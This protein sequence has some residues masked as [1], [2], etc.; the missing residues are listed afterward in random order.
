MGMGMG[1]SCSMMERSATMDGMRMGG[2]KGSDSTGMMGG[3]RMGMMGGGHM[4]MMP[5]SRMMMAG[6]R[7]MPDRVLGLAD[8]LGLTEQQVAQI[9]EIKDS[10]DPQ[11]GHE[12]MDQ[13]FEA[14]EQAF[15]AE[16]PNPEA[17]QATAEAALTM[18]AQMQ[19]R[20]LATATAVRAVL[21]GEQRDRLEASGGCSMSG[22]QRSGM[23]DRDTEGQRKQL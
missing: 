22:S 10:M 3:G 11:Q 23:H 19:A 2:M 17:V 21:S 16:E 12:S 15:E 13:R 1:M 14:L 18:R 5:A 8:S 7:F 4:G 6:M 20:H 9:R